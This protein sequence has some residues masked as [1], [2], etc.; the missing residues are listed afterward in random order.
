MT[1]STVQINF[2]DATSAIEAEHSAM[3]KVHHLLNMLIQQKGVN[4]EAANWPDFDDWIIARFFWMLINDHD[5]CPIR[6][7][8]IYVRVVPG[9][10]TRASYTP[11]YNPEYNIRDIVS[12]VKSQADADE[13]VLAP[14]I[15]HELRMFHSKVECALRWMH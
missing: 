10:F 9:L 11:E 3:S 4:S 8:E 15:V 12:I 1:F 13:T 14:W 5:V 7:Q 2:M 6:A